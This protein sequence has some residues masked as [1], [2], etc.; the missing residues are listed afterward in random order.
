MARW[1]ELKNYTAVG[2]EYGLSAARVSQIVAGGVSQI[3]AG[4]GGKTYPQFYRQNRR[5]VISLAADEVNGTARR[6]GFLGSV[7]WSD[8][9]SVSERIRFWAAI[10]Q[11]QREIEAKRPGRFTPADMERVRAMIDKRIPRP[12]TVDERKLFALAIAVRDGMAA[13][14]AEDAIKRSGEA[15]ASAGAREP[16]NITS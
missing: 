11:H 5:L 10:D 15:P 4:D 12:C 16:A 6:I 13:F 3:V 8:P 7:V 9:I 2:R 1:E 14:D